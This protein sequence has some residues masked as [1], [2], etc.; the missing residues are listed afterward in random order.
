MSGYE[1]YVPEDFD[2]FWREAA[3]QARQAPLDFRRSVGAP[4]TWSDFRVETIQFRGMGG[5][6]LHGWLAY[7][8]GA[9]RLPS[10]L[11][12]PP[13]GQASSLP[14]EYTTRPGFV[15]F[16]FNFHG[17]PAFH[18]EE[19]TPLRGY[20]SVGAADPHT[21]IF[22]TMLQ[23]VLIALR[24]LQALPEVEEN[25]IG[26]MG[27]SQGGGMA[28]WAGAWSPIVKAVCADLPFLGAARHS[29]KAAAHRYPPKEL[30]DFMKSEFLGEEKVMYTLAYYDTMNHATRCRVP[31]L[32]SSGR[33][34]PAVR[35]QAVQAIYDT[36]P[37]PKRWI[38]YETGHDWNPDMVRNNQAWLEHYLLGKPF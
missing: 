14:N 11:W 37:G 21:W 38:Q 1:P 25:A 32:V 7:P 28:I 24:L 35:P 18:Q 19:Y 15:S 33:A 2:A 31:T 4:Y 26:A 17:H 3:E 30:V 29:I 16:S 36:L 20:F 23:N 8:P 27:L 12:I 9:R 13:Y 5:Y 22:R 10:F 34:D 6:E